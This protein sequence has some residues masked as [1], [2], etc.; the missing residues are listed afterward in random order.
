M[1]EKMKREER[2]LRWESCYYYYYYY[3]CSV[4]IK[5]L[6]NAKRCCSERVTPL[7]PMLP[8]AATRCSEP[9]LPN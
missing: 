1:M 4:Q 6:S 3:Y 8:L 7:Q 9:T 5:P 2:E